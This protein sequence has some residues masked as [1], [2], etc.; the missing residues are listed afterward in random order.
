MCTRTTVG[1]KFVDSVCS[2]ARKFFNSLY[3]NYSGKEVCWQL[4]T[5]T[6]VA[7]KFVTVYTPAIVAR[8][9]AD[10]V[11]SNYSGKEVC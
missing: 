7:R 3:P 8:K 5:P 10:R 4:Y 9:F 11:C 2:V 6:T 1:G